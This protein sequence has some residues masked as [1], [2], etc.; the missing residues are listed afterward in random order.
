[1][2][3]KVLGIIQPKVSK[4]SEPKYEYISRDGAMATYRTHYPKFKVRILVPLPRNDR[5]PK[6]NYNP[7]RIQKIGI[8]T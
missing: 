6:K 3:I 4:A 1:M 2:K 5:T 7:V 8:R